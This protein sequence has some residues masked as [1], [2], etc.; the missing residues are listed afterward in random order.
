MNRITNIILGCL[1]IIYVLSPLDLLPEAILGPF[2]LPDDLVALFVAI[3][4]FKQA[5]SGQPSPVTVIDAEYH[6]R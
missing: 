2:G 3:K 6:V 5:A 1:C 4:K